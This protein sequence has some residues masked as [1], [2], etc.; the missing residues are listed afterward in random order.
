LLVLVVMSVRTWRKISNAPDRLLI[1]A[2]IV[3]AVV[4][5]IFLAISTPNFGTLARYR[6]GFLPFLIVLLVSQP[7]LVR[8]LAK[9][10]NVHIADLSR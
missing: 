6:I 9:I 2:V 8:T 5:C 3:Y 10:F 4:L 7:W 1:L